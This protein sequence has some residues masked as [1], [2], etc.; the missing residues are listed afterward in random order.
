M[1]LP[2]RATGLQTTN[3]REAEDGFYWAWCQSA[4]VSLSSPEVVFHPFTLPASKKF[5]LTTGSVANHRDVGFEASRLAGL[6]LFRRALRQRDF[7]VHV[8]LP[9]RVVSWNFR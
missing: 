1:G 8:K 7:L 9:N 6:P 5:N 3:Q 4:L 2:E